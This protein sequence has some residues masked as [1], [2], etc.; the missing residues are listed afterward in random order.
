MKKLVY[1]ITIL[2]V[3]LLITSCQSDYGVENKPVQS[4]PEGKTVLGKQLQNPYSVTNMNIAYENL[5]KSGK[6]QEE[7]KIQPTNLYVRLL[8]ENYETYDK[9]V[10]DKTLDLFDYPIDYEIVQ[11]GNFYHD[12]S[13]P[14]THPTWQYTVVS[15]DY[16]PPTGVKMEVLEKLYLPEQ[17]IKISKN[18]SK[19]NE[20]L[21]EELEYESLKITG[22]LSD[23]NSLSKGS[24]WGLPAKWRPAGKIQVWDNRLQK[25]VG[26]AGVKVRAWRLFG[27]VVEGITDNNGNFSCDG[28]FR[29]DANY[30]IVWETEKFDI[31]SGTFGQAKYDGPKIKGDWNLKINGGIQSTYAHVFRGAY[32]YS[33][34]DIGG[35]SR[36]NLPL[37]LKY[38]VYDERGEDQ[39]VNIGNWTVFGSNP[40]ILIYRY[41]S[42]GYEYSSDEIFSTTCHETAH[43]THLQIM[44]GAV[45]FG[46][47]NEEIRESWA[48]GVEWFI[49]Q[50]E[51]KERG[52]SNYADPNYTDG[53]F[54]PIQYG[55]QHWFSINSEYSPVFIDLVDNYN[56]LGQ[57]FPGKNNGTINDAVTGYTLASIESG[58]LN[59]VYRMNPIM[60]VG[61]NP[62][63]SSL[64]S[65]LKANKPTGVTNTQIDKL[66][67]SY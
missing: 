52:I 49:T 32:R 51:Y 5:K 58:F 27:G 43:T 18:L 26:I 25:Y 38:A 35:L 29:Y 21:I 7:L 57:S 48:V 37:K 19:Q 62:I 6:I 4:I 61:K 20:L 11:Q 22:N 56:Q 67:D 46:M 64:R 23:V 59:K 16:Q 39:G 2:T 47:I 34:G 54:Y 41:S 33:Y 36:P 24:G 45:N 10:N 3:V 9:L 15:L 53:D 44:N 13:I 63:G 60:V 31:R 65:E 8:P 40:N 1:M 55:Y 17:A 28:E 14:E 42:N 30:C 50:K 66:I 12:T